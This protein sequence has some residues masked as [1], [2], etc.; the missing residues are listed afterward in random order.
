MHQQLE[1]LS[2]QL[3]VDNEAAT[4]AKQAVVAP[5]AKYQKLS[6]QLNSMT[7]SYDAAV[8]DGTSAIGCSILVMF[9]YSAG[10]CSPQNPLD[11]FVIAN[12]N[13]LKSQYDSALTAFQ[14][15][16]D[17]ASKTIQTYYADGTKKE[18]LVASLDLVTQEN[19][20]FQQELST[21]SSFNSSVSDY[22]NQLATINSLEAKAKIVS[23]NSQ[24]QIQNLLSSKHWSTDFPLAFQ[25]YA[26][27]NQ[28]FKELT[29]AQSS[30]NGPPNV[31]NF[32]ANVFWLPHGFY[33]GS[34]YPSLNL[35]GP[36]FGWAWSN[37]Y[38]CTGVC[39]VALMVS[40]SNCVGA[41]VT[42]DWK[43]STGAKVG[44]TTSTLPSM[45]TGT[46][47]QV[48]FTLPATL[49]TS[50][51]YSGFLSGFQCTISQL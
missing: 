23:L 38:Q 37:Y 2:S 14:D 42:I 27:A 28:N 48:G 35:G 41:S 5:L 46:V 1:V 32:S 13:S 22:A 11:T 8:S 9:G 10:P 31:P 34:S 51:S 20:G 25:V 15:A 3:S 39:D 16:Q 36:D 6:S 18:I 29:S 12:Y 30:D 21:L 4:S 26:S 47:Y 24:N 40:K 49:D 33:Q 19:T 44:A 43:D 17:L 45:T 7:A 50:K